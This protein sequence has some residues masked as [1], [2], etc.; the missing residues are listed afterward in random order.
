MRILDVVCLFVFDMF[1]PDVYRDFTTNE[2]RLQF[3]LWNDWIT[4]L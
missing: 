1:T 4:L 2:N 3:I